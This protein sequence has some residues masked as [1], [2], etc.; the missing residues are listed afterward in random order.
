MQK[1]AVLFILAAALFFLPACRSSASQT[2]SGPGSEYGSVQKT[3]EYLTS[4]ECNGRL[5]GTDGNLSAQKYIMDSLSSFGIEKYNGKYE[6][7]F[8]HNQLT[9]KEIT[10]ET[11][12]KKF[13]YGKDFYISKISDSDITCPLAAETNI[14]DGCV[15]LSENRDNVN[16]LLSNPKVKAILVKTGSMIFFNL[17]EN[18]ISDKTVL[19]VMDDAYDYLK[20]HTGTGVR[21]KS[22]YALEERYDHNIIG[23]IKGNNSKKAILLSAHFDHVGAAGNH[24]FR[25]AVDNASGVAALLCAAKRISESAKADKPDTDII[26]AFF[27]A[28]ESMMLGSKDFA[29][30]IQKQYGSENILNINIDCI[31]NINNDILNIGCSKADFEGVIQ[32]LADQLKEKSIGNIELRQADTESNSDHV[33][34]DNYVY[35]YMESKKI[36]TLSDTISE[37]DA[38]LVES[39]GE[40][41]AEL[42]LNIPENKVGAAGEKTTVQMDTAEKI[43][44]EEARKLKPF[45]YKFMKVDGEIKYVGWYDLSGQY[46]EVNKYLGGELDTIPARILNETMQNFVSLSF[47]YTDEIV[48]SSQKLDTVYKR[49]YRYSDMSQFSM[50]GFKPVSTDDVRSIVLDIIK[51]DY[52][53]RGQ[54]N[55]FNG[56]VKKFGSDVFE[57]KE[58]TLHY[59]LREG[60][61]G[62]IKCVSKKSNDQVKYIFTISTELIESF[63]KDK[64]IKLID[65]YDMFATCDAIIDFMNQ[66]GE[67]SCENA[68]AE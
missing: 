65:D 30:R 55:L 49:N 50:G 46:D 8:L 67:I 57:Y 5:V 29:E 32:E 16:E 51:M 60:T 12:E 37:V 14:T 68:G 22:S 40:C 7:K 59:Q 52:S 39:V 33:W 58:H 56:F 42:V 18:I 24:I 38:K 53:L 35:L 48:Y 27:N 25:G 2:T 11:P 61:G 36:H 17:T 45:E 6:D 10:L 66:P 3:L 9:V 47:S 62:E 13:E 31:S 19:L 43:I 44:S 21:L 1:K 54:E 34:F 15:V 41:A 64:I 23:M 28:E 4:D 26:F 20:E 63:D